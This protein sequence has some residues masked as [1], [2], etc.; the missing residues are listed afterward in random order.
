MSFLTTSH[1]FLSSFRTELLSL[2]S[3]RDEDEN[4]S[5]EENHDQD[6]HSIKSGVKLE[7][8]INKVFLQ[9]R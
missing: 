3:E 9:S 8:W 1:M 6:H 5:L 4:D 2:T 7:I